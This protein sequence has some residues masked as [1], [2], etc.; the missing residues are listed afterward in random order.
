MENVRKN[1][2]S[3][4]GELPFVMDVL[5][6]E[7]PKVVETE[8]AFLFGAGSGDQVLRFQYSMTSGL[9]VWF[10]THWFI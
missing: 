9:T 2:R 10:Y 5:S 1:V 4:V 6:L 7:E 3:V 8:G